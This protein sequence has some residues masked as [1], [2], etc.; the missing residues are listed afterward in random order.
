MRVW[1]YFFGY[2]LPLNKRSEFMGNDGQSKAIGDFVLKILFQIVKFIRAMMTGVM[3]L[4][5]LKILGIGVVVVIVSILLKMYSSNFMIFIEGIYTGE[6][7]AIVNGYILI[8]KFIFSYMPIIA[9]IV[10][11]IIVG[12]LK[13][14]KETSKK[15]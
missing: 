14:D 3:R 6:K 12:L 4:R 11:L 13:M 15:K 5:D 10:Y 9:L 7:N 1:I 2:P 8:C